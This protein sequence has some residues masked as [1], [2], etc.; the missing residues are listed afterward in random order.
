MTAPTLP[1]ARPCPECGTEIAAALLACPG[2]RSLVHREAL[3]W[4][5]ARARM[6]EERG[7]VR[8][9]L[10]E[11]REALPLV[12]HDARQFQVI[13]ER[14]AAL[15]RQA[16]TLPDDHTPATEAPDPSRPLHLRLW[17]TLAAVAL[18]AIGKGKFLLAGLTKLPTLLSM[19]AAFALYWSVFG[20]Q[21]AAGVIFC[22]YLHEMGHV[23][24]LARYG[25]R[26]TALMF[27]PG[28]GAF[29]TYG[30]RLADPRQ[31]A[32]VSLA[33]PVWGAGAGLLF[34]AVARITEAP[35]LG[36]IGATAGAINLL[37]LLPIPPLDGSQAFR[38]LTR[39]QRL[40]IGV[41]LLLMWWQLD[42]NWAGLTGA[43]IT[44]FA[45]FSKP[46]READHEAF[47]WFVLVAAVLGW[48]STTYAITPEGAR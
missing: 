42:A 16:E 45:L 2:C 29:V 46:A 22:I 26:S 38:V 3:E 36:A 32:L 25:V 23:A 12:P 40:A 30:Q 33:G 7:D 18:F 14:I 9:A 5:A 15:G 27:V 44:G 21:W 28:L 35:V 19:F 41:A 47:A 43:V 24:V 11:W 17:G 48:L 4:R 20:W 1:Q 34:Y 37:N 39:G 31:E 10:A 6:A 13:Q 8:A